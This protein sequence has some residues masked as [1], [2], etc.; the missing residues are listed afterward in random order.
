M[1][2]L[3][4]SQFFSTTRGGG[5]YVFVL[6]AKK[7]AENGHKVWVIA[8]KVSKERYEESKNI[9]IILVKP[10][11]EYK[12]GLPPSFC[13]NLRYSLNAI[14]DGMRV[15]KKENIDIIQSNNFAPAIAGSILSYLTS[16]PHITTVH[17]IFS[18]CDK[19]FWKKWGAQNNISKI[20][21]L[22]GPLFE[23][24]FVK[25]RCDCIHTVSE[26]TKEDLVKFGAKKP[27]YV[28][29]NA[30]NI[31]NAT[32]KNPNPLQFLYLGRLV[33]FKN[34][35]LII[36]AV[37]IVKES[38]PKIKLI[39]A[40]GGPQR[41]VLE[42]LVEKLHLKQNVEF[43]G[44]VSANEK[45]ELISSSHALV[46]PSYC[47]GF[48]LVILEAFSFRRPVLVSNIRPMSDIVSNG[49]TGY[50][51]DP[52]D[53]REWAKIMIELSQDPVKA[54]EMGQSGL[55]ILKL[56]YNPKDMY[57]KIINMYEKFVKK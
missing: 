22:L 40:G 23:K 17:D 24:L 36:K 38:Q 8:N 11:L 32:E 45:T 13:D 26:A 35:E 25:L 30:I 37:N 1:N 48:G 50:V 31:P 10:T 2:V 41:E 6:I 54:L 19:N 9:K 28:I 56:K 47:E 46:F 44:Y 55:E 53:E 29:N 43:K 12:G 5:E 27:I 7:L 33:F 18:L 15:I 16:K 39:I 52:N 57:E 14:K 42:N 3:L 4:L 51:L 34:I 49:K 21:V 20:N